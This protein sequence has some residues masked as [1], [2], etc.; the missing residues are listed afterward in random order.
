MWANNEVGTVQDIPALA[1][2]AHERGI[3]IHTDAVQAFGHVPVDFTAADV[4]LLTITAHKVGGPVGVG[5]LVAKRTAAIVPL[6]HGGGQE[7]QVRSGTLDAA[8]VRAFAVAACEATGRREHETARLMALRD[9]LIKGA[10]AIDGEIRPGGWWEAG[11]ATRRLAGNAHL[12]VPGCEGDSLLYLLDAAGIECSTGSACQAGVPQPSHVLLAM[13]LSEAEARG[14]L[15][16][17]LGHSSTDADIDAV[18][19][20]LPSAVARARRASGGAA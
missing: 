15:R 6:I 8:G 3:P 20:V 16:F 7:R 17:T 9:R 1:A 10:L 11:D 14:A 13:G 19:A 12:V 4:D 2:I 5:A 18:L